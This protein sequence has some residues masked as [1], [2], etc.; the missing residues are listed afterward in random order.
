MRQDVFDSFVALEHKGT[1]GMKPEAKRYLEKCIKLGKRN[2]KI[3]QNKIETTKL[4]NCVYL[5]GHCF[6]C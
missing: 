6:Y 4:L 3:Y 5:L 2:G 1:D